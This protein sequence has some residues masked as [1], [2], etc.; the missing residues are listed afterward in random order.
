M[1]VVALATWAAHPLFAIA[2]RLFLGSGG[3]GDGVGKLPPP[4]LRHEEVLFSKSG[5]DADHLKGRRGM[6]GSG[7]IGGRRRDSEGPMC[8]RVMSVNSGNPQDADD[9]PG[10]KGAHCAARG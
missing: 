1:R 8:S 6:E 9:K 5:C 2:R 7:R 4:P 3:A 10:G